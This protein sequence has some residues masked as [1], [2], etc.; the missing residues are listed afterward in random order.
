MFVQVDLAELANGVGDF[1]G[2]PKQAAPV[3]TSVVR[4]RQ[5][6]PKVHCGGKEVNKGTRSGVIA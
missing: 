4:L 3:S 2:R 1:E 5:W 6:I